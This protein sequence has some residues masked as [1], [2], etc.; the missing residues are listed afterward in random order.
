MLKTEFG[1][2]ILSKY[3]DSNIFQLPNLQFIG[4]LTNLA[5]NGFTLLFH[6]LLIY[7]IQKFCHLN[8]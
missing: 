4:I 6:L 5:D 2:K 8:S 3:L 1:M 7:L